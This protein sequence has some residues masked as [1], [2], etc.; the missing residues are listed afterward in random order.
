MDAGWAVFL[1]AVV[2][3]V[4]GLLTVLLQQFR[5]EN[6][7]DHDI[8]MGMLKMVYKKQG[9]VEYKIDKVSDKLSEHLENHPK[10]SQ[11]NSWGWYLGRSYDS[12]NTRNNPQI[13]SNRKGFPPRRGRILPR[14]QRAGPN[15][16]RN[17][18]AHR[19]TK[20]LTWQKG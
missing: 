5:K 19:R 13:P 1:A 11:D 18:A 9:T 16:G 14:T 15:V 20:L 6:A 8:V 7:K 17:V 4:G 12:P 3:S 10:L 2:S